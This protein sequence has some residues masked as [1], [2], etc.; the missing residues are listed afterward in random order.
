MTLARITGLAAAAAALLAAPAT[1]QETGWTTVGR[2]SL[3]PDAAS[4]TMK[5]RWDPQFRQ[6]MFCT[7]GHAIKLGDATLRFEDGTAKVVKVRQ[8]LADGGC[9]KPIAVPRKSHVATVDI[10]YDSATVAGG[11][12]KVQLVAR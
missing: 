4:S 12:A 5:V 7:D 10:A 2:A 3:G 11:K 9:S 8:K 6:G 1:A